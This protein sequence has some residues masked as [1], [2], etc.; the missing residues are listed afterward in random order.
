[1]F[2]TNSTGQQLEASALDFPF[3]GSWLAYL[4]CPL[5]LIFYISRTSYIQGP[6]KSPRGCRRLGLEGPSNLV[7]EF[8]SKY[9]QG[10]PD[11]SKDHLWKVKSLWIY[12]VKSCRGVELEKGTVVK[13]GLEYDRQ[14]S[15]AQWKETRNKDTPDDQKGPLQWTFITQREFPLL[16]RVRTEIWIPDPSS[17]TYSAKLPEV[18]SGGVM[19]LIFPHQYH[20]RKGLLPR[21]I[22]KISGKA[23]EM[24]FQVPFDP[25]QLQ[26]Q[27]SGY[28]RQTMKI[29]KD[30]PIALNMTRC[31][32][33]EL[34][35]F[36]GVKKPMGLFRVDSDHY[37]QV[38]RNAPRKET[39][40]YQPIVGFA[41]AYPLHIMNL[42]SVHDLASR[43]ENGPPELSVG[44]FRSNIIVTGPLAFSEDHWKKLRI[45][46][47]VYDV[48]CRTA[49]CKLPNTDQITGE[50]HRKEPD[51]VLRSYRKI[52][53]GVSAHAC[54]GMQMVPMTESSNIKVGDIIEV[55]EIGK[56]FYMMQ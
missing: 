22:A 8:D 4:L 13:T 10:T 23:T 15:F 32:P 27:E 52:D 31:V 51:N 24:S 28:S 33:N 55:L 29:W 30:S 41:D 56:H 14:F 46:D 18:Q 44:R 1:M 16:A 38:F 54:L 25:T 35:Q 40:G 48:S 7:D 12:P 9:A 45:G 21:L 17:P 26:I 2:D 47:G 3:T 42:A 37:R 43:I 34:K 53:E 36:L 19:V 39:L 50:K 5:M 11:Q 6:K 20:G 49:R